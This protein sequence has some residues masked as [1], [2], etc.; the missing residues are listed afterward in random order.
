MKIR[1]AQINDLNELENISEEQFHFENLRP[2]FN[3]LIFNND[4]VVKVIEIKK[5]IFGFMVL[6]HVDKNVIDIYSIAIKNKYQNKGYGYKFLKDTVKSFSNYKITLEVSENNSA[7]KL[8]LKCG[9]K[10]DSVR[11]QYY[12][13][14]DAILM[15]YIKD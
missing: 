14:S 15:S 7:K 5:N 1:V 9:F 10:I 6:K 3:N 4:Y 11:K 8:Y 2:K 12:P 13:D